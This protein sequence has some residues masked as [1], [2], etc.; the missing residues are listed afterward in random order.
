M[1]A[2]TAAVRRLRCENAVE[3]KNTPALRYS[4]RN[5]KLMTPTGVSVSTSLRRTA[6][7]YRA[8]DLESVT[9]AVAGQR[10]TP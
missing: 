6:Q 1:T 9:G 10:R 8:N 5:A 4:E 2:T 7:Q 3:T